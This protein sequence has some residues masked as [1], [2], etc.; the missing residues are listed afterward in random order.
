MGAINGVVI[1]SL[2]PANSIIFTLLLNTGSGKGGT[3]EGTTIGL[4]RLKNLKRMYGLTYQIA[5]TLVGA[6]FVFRNHLHSPCQL[7]RY[8]GFPYM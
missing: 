8:F 7:G 5:C 3:M 2:L 4:E 1:P 6:L